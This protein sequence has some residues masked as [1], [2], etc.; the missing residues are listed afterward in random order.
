MGDTMTRQRRVYRRGI[1]NRL[2]ARQY[3]KC[4]YCG[5]LV[6]VAEQRGVAW[7]IEHIVPRAV[8]KWLER[9]L[10]PREVDELFKLIEDNNNIAITHYECNFTRGCSLPTVDGIKNMSI[11][12]DLEII[13]LNTLNKTQDYINIYRSI[14]N[15]TLEKQEYKC[16]RCG[17]LLYEDDT[18]LRRRRKD[19]I[20]N[21]KN[22]IA[23]CNCCNEYVSKGK[24]GSIR[25]SEYR[26]RK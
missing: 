12:N 17:K 18:V 9:I 15:S 21:P 2:Y 3:G 8:F 24:Y 16:G 25:H 14:V 7:S 11:P 5:K 20:R 4:V 10:L 13:Y 23:Y 22:A 6:D 1:V 19:R 26:Y